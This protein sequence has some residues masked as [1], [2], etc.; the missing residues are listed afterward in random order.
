LWEVIQKIAF[1]ALFY[2]HFLAMPTAIY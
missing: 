1:L 2:F